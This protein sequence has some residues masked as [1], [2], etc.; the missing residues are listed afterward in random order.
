MVPMNPGYWIPAARSLRLRTSAAL[1]VKA[2]KAVREVFPSSSER[3]GMM[4][5]FPVPA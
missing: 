2:Q 4:V 5:L 3:T 1:P